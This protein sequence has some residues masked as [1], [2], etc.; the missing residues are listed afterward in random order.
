MKL[1]VSLPAQ[2]LEVFSDRGDL[3]HRYPVSTGKNGAGEQRGSYMT[4]RGR[5]IIRAKIGAGCPENTV[6]VR[7][8]PTGELWSP[9]LAAQFPE[10]DWIMARILWLSGCEPGFNRLGEVDTMRR[11]IYFHGCADTA[12]LGVPGSAGC[13]RMRNRDIVE[14]F[15]LVPVYSEVYIG[16]Y[17]IDEGPWTELG[18]AARFV[19]ERVF[20][21]EQGIDAGQEWDEHDARARHV[22]ATDA[23][24]QAIGTARLLETQSG[25]RIGRLCVLPAWRGKGV[26][27]G[28]MRRLL[29]VASRP[30]VSP[31]N[32]PLYL[33]ARV[34]AADFY[35]RL[36]F[37][38]D[39]EPFMEVGAPHVRMVRFI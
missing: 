10:R 3:L 23:Q 26:G 22:V 39:G 34:E 9:E 4:P 32:I 33:H 25:G 36:G 15:G 6:F 14:L 19:R 5:H 16:E 11:F 8:R 12:E 38:A 37:V 35:G 18:S 2:T 20:I 31:G 27:L 1:F 13:V 17:R 28:L 21:L 24:G 30:E 7:R 29:E